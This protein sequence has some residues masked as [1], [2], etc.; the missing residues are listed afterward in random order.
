MDENFRDKHS[1][2]EKVVSQEI[3]F[4]YSH[5]INVI[6]FHVFNVK[7]LRYVIK[8][9][10]LLPDTAQLLCLIC[11]IVTLKAFKMYTFLSNSLT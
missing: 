7:C 10:S 1:E 6:M 11:Y 5:E 2:Q 9:S 8:N 4:L 3:M